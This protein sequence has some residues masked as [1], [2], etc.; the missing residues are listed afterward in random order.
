M[1]QTVEEA[2]KFFPSPGPPSLFKKSGVFW[3]DA[4]GDRTR[5]S[6]GDDLAAGGPEGKQGTVNTMN[7]VNTVN[8]ASQMPTAFFREERLVGRNTPRD[9]LPSFF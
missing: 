7:T 6:R 1:A 3:G 2:K 4:R 9:F 5:P 8:T